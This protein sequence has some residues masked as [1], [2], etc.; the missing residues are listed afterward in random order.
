[1]TRLISVTFIIILTCIGCDLFHNDIEKIPE[2][3]YTG[4]FQRQFA[5]G[6]GD[7]AN[8][9]MTFHSNDWTGQSNKTIFPALCHVTYK[10]DKKKIELLKKELNYL[11]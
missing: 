5:F 7:T 10:F 9:T 1:M 8:V 4:T 11:N 6:G 2:G 3:V